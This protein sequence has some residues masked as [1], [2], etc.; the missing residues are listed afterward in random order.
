MVAPESTPGRL[1]RSPGSGNPAK[2]IEQ[3]WFQLRSASVRFSSKTLCIDAD[4]FNR[5]KSSKLLKI[6]PLD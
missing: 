1:T 2:R 4:I 5:Q 6:K 3:S